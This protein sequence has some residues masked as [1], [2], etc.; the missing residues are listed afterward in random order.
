MRL[1]EVIS[2]IAITDRRGR[3]DCP[4]TGITPNSQSVHPGS[5][6]VAVRGLSAD[7]HDY[8]RQA[9]K[10]GATS[11]LAESWTDQL[12]GGGNGR[13]QVVLVPNSRRALALAAAN[14]YGQPSRKL[15]IAGVTGTN[16]KTTVTY[17]LDSIMRAASRK[18][19]LIG[20][21]GARYDDQLIEATHTTPDAVQLQGTLAQMVEA[22]VTH[23][24]MEVSSHALDQQ[25]VAGINF[26]VAGFTN[27]TQDHLDYHKT[28]DTYF[29][30][31]ARLFSD[32]LRKSRARGRMA[33]VNVDDPKG[34]ELVGVWGGKSLRTSIDP[35]SDA[36]V[37]ALQATCALN[38]TEL[39]VRTPKGVWE[40]SYAL[41]GTHNV[42]NVLVAMG[43]ALAMGFSKARIVR[44]L[45]ALERVQG[46][47]EPVP[48]ADGKTV[49]IDYAHTPDA[50]RRTLESF[51]PLT[52]GRLVVVFGCG[53]DRDSDK[54]PKMGQ[55][56][57]EL[58]DLA[59]VT[60]DNPRTEDAVRIAAAVEEGLQAGGFKEM[61]AT[62]VKGTYAVELDRRGAIRT[63]IKWLEED[64]VLVIAGKGH[65][66]YQIIGSRKR[67][68]D[69]AEE[70][71]RALAGQPPPLPE[72]LEFDDATGEVE[73]DA[74]IDEL[75][76]LDAADLD[77]QDVEVLS[78][79]DVEEV[80]PAEIEEISAADV[81]EIA[82]AD[83]L[84]AAA[85]VAKSKFGGAAAEV[86]TSMPHAPADASGIIEETASEAEDP[87]DRPS[88]APTT[89]GDD[90]PAASAE[91]ADGAALAAAPEV[92][93]SSDAVAAADDAEPEVAAAAAQD[94]ASDAEAAPASDSAE[95]DDGTPDATDEVVEVAAA[96]ADAAAVTASADQAPSEAS[97]DDAAEAKP[98]ATDA[99]AEAEAAPEAA[100]A[101]PEAAE[102]ASDSPAPASGSADDEAPEAASG[103]PPGDGKT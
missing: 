15:L 40:L 70:A 44:G 28:I 97:P 30:A 72:G 49:F 60:N 51:R 19:G 53:G 1:D 46:R 57:A 84:V 71:R 21:V 10:A 52:K 25:R 5:M 73:D 12:D 81:E 38:G 18:V 90:T 95:A 8:V 83:V 34:E 65:E 45:R 96:S 14:Y 67:H 91:A 87:A 39:T 75:D 58:A 85:P 41:V 33:V 93:G 9:V 29:K 66:D 77:S 100:D 56:V 69:D 74:V 99:A 88:G 4:V 7:G 55:A 94:D 2:G 35:N 31:K 68:F 24:V 36:D 17:I 26:K 54:R 3:L 86:D 98:S 76:D 59:V 61:E 43:M 6:F 16:G 101:A 48:N 63:A 103:D 92:S 102:A 27:L 11:I 62:P 78:A 37:V 50:L 13:P 79:S 82:D 22:G 47:V 42:S 80:S 23:V 89:P 64:D 20:T 32:S